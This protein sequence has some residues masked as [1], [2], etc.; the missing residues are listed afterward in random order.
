MPMR[1]RQKPR[2]LVEHVETTWGNQPPD[3][4]PS[5]L[6]FPVNPA[7]S[8]ASPVLQKPLKLRCMR[9]TPLSRA[10]PPPPS[11]ANSAVFGGGPQTRFAG[12]I[13]SVRA[14]KSPSTPVNLR[15]L[16]GRSTMS[17]CC[18][19]NSKR[20]EPVRPELSLS[21]PLPCLQRYVNGSPEKQRRVTRQTPVVKSLLSPKQA[22]YHVRRRGPLPPEPITPE[23]TRKLVGQSGHHRIT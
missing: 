2:V 16:Q 8:L 11:P 23:N 14:C 10:L 9:K 7:L 17:S 20:F 1:T 19:S 22:P 5:T 18:A 4:P 21:S 15:R 12:T 3:S 13:S 6:R